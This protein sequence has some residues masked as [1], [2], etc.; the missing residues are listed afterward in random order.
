MRCVSKAARR[1]SMMRSTASVS[2]IGWVGCVQPSSRDRVP[3]GAKHGDVPGSL[4][5]EEEVF[6]DR[7]L[8]WL[9]SGETNASRREERLVHDNASSGSADPCGGR[10]EGG[11]R[12]GQLRHCTG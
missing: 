11:H 12:V 6:G 8:R 2:A 4:V 10:N 7:W 9:S 5:L 1:S 3:S